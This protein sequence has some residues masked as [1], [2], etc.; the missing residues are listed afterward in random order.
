M[1]NSPMYTILSR[2]SLFEVLRVLNTSQV[3][4]A[5]TV[6][7]QCSN[8]RSTHTRTI[9]SSQDLNRILF[10]GVLLVG[11]VQDLA[12]GNCTSLLEVGVFVE[13][14]SIGSDVAGLV[15]LLL[16]DCCDTTSGETGCS[17]ADEFSQTTNEFQFRTVRNDAK[18]ILEEV[19]SLGQVLKWIPW[20]MLAGFQIPRWNYVL[21]DQ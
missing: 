17:S 19:C 15:T 6:Q 21:F 13:N 8:E 20:L 18:L 11:P 14:R 1:Y 16:C 9:L 10:L 5:N 2:P 12:Q 3:A 7:S 4:L